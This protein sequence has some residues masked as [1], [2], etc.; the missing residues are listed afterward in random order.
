VRGT[1]PGTNRN[2]KGMEIKQ[3][4]CFVAV[5]EELHFAKAAERLGID[6]SL[7]SRQVR[8]LERALGTRLLW[9]T[10]RQTRLTEAGERLLIDAVHVLMLLDAMRQTEAHRLQRRVTVH[11]GG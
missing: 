11:A 8:A 9:R 6:Q 7:L 2:V 3:L 10:T 4:R 1:G 5:A